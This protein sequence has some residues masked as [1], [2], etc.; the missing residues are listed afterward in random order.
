MRWKKESEYT[1]ALAN[2]IQSNVTGSASDS[3]HGTIKSEASEV[4]KCLPSLVP[5]NGP[6]LDS[7]TS[8]TNSFV[9]LISFRLLK[10]HTVG[11]YIMGRRIEI[12]AIQDDRK[13][14]T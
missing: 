13:R 7:V 6:M 4:V 1:L 3:G 11:T 14:R 10:Q 8:Y 9:S 12:K 5:I 2:P